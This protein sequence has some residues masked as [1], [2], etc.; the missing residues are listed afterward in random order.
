M[1][2]KSDWYSVFQGHRKFDLFGERNEK[3]HRVQRR[4]VSRIYAMDSLKELES[5]VDDAIKV[6]LTRMR[7]RQ[8]QVVN[9]GLWVQLYAFGMP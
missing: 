7:E 5:Y 3:I 2:R 8:G 4:L 1:F 6:F 9:M